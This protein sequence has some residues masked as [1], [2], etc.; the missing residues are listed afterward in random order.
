MRNMLLAFAPVLLSGT[1]TAQGVFSNKTQ[2]VLEKVI[3]DYPNHFLNIKGEL[4][5]HATQATRYQSTLQLPGAASTVVLV[6]S[7]SAGSGWACTVLE[8]PSFETAKS[9]YAEIFGQLSNS[10]INSASQKTFILSGQY[11]APTEDR[12]ISHVLFSLLPG[13][14]DLKNLRVDLSLVQEG[15]TWKIYLSVQDAG[16]MQGAITSN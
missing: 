13:V 14:G 5:S 7:G 9:R 11:E 1:L 16:S 12:K 2:A 3:Q 4:I 15:Q 10:I 6:A 8:T